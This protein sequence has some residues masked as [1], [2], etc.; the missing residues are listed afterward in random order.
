MKDKD[1]L[2]EGSAVTRH[3]KNDFGFTRHNERDIKRPVS[4]D[5]RHGSVLMCEV[6][7]KLSGLLINK[8]LERVTVKIFT[9]VFINN[10]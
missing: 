7:E 10:I 2:N 9:N 4:L 1:T 5:T 3:K 8:F 6:I